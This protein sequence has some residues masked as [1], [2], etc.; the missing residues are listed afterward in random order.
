MTAWS[1][2]GLGDYPPVPNYGYASVH[3]NLIMWSMELPF[4]S[5]GTDCLL[6]Q[7]WWQTCPVVRVV[8]GGNTTYGIQ[9]C[10]HMVSVMVTSGHQRAWVLENFIQDI[11]IPNSNIY[12]QVKTK[13][14]RRAGDGLGLRWLQRKTWLLWVYS[15]RIFPYWKYCYE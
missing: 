14:N 15:D 6:T 5:Q 4:F 3:Y 11:I 1:K 8:Q 9:G 7:P 10:P 13:P 12:L 2:Y